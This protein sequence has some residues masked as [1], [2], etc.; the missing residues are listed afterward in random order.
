MPTYADTASSKAAAPRAIGGATLAVKT[1]DGHLFGSPTAEQPM[2]VVVYRGGAFRTIL[3]VT[4][5]DGDVLEIDGTFDDYDDAAVLA[6]DQIENVPTAGDFNDIYTAIDAIS[7]TPGP[8]GLQGPAGN[9]G[10]QGIQGVPGPAGAKGD[11][12]DVGPA[13]TTST[14][15]ILSG[16]GTNIS[17]A[18]PG[19]DYVSPSGLT[20][21]L[22]T[23]AD[24]S[25]VAHLSG[26]EVLS[27]K[28]L[29]TPA[30]KG[31]STTD[32][33]Q[34]LNSSETLVGNFDQNGYGFVEKATFLLALRSDL[35]TGTNVTNQ[36]VIASAPGKLWKCKVQAATNPSGGGFSFTLK[37]NGTAIYSTAQVVP[38]S[39]TTVQSFNTFSSTSV[40]EDDVFTIDV[41]AAGG[42]VRVI[43]VTL[44]YLVRNA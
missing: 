43:N 11:Q 17:A 35:A 8:Q 41:T 39:T 38:A 31:N 37:Q 9:D 3:K 10:P 33:L 25:T 28:T 6:G 2:R 15:G 30:V 27:G 26:T 32:I 20:T 42:G 1:G 19:T 5:V 14:V 34:L 18:T 29:V 40:A 44:F 23:K 36:G 24:D 21:A 12:G 22:S 7:L 13:F 4:G 16:D